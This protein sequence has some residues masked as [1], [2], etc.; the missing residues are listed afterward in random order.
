MKNKSR[1]TKKAQIIIDKLL[2]LGSLCASNPLLKAKLE[3]MLDMARELE[4]DI[5]RS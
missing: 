4:F 5:D 1:A 2:D 3:R